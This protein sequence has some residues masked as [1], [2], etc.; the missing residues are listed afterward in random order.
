MEKQGAFYE[1]SHSSDAVLNRSS[2]VTH[3]H[4][5]GQSQCPDLHPRP[6]LAQSGRWLDRCRNLRSFRHQSQHLDPG[7]ATVPGRSAGSRA[8]RQAA[9]TSSPGALWWTGGPS[10]GHGLHARPR[11]PRPLDRTLAGR[12]RGRTRLCRVHLPR[13]HSPAAQKNELKPWQHEQWC[14]PGSVAK[15]PMIW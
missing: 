4:P 5:R 14:I 9:T 15:M 2:L 10:A 13:N 1:T 6:G 7:A 11:W 12:P 3:V 8:A